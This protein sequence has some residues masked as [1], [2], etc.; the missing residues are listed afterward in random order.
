[1]TDN[2]EI[3]T[4]SD[5]SHTI[6]NRELNETYHSIHG[7]VQESMHV[8]I[9]NGL[10][11]FQ[12]RTDSG[13]ISILEVGFGTGLNALLA[14]EYAHERKVRLRYTTLEP[15]P[16]EK[17]VWSSLNY[18]VNGRQHFTSIHEVTWGCDVAVTPMFTIVKQRTSLERA[19]LRENV[20]VIFFDAFAPSVQPELWAYDSLRK[21]T[22]KLNPG[23][24]FVTYSARGQL[25]RDLKAM[26]LHIETLPGPPGKMQMVRATRN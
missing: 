18:G 7:A 4:T 19:V 26:G 24:V 6:R 13:V 9:R 11:Y 3:I 21:V 22:E 20:D 25:K 1:M 15:F 2:L 12:H 14:L 5:G 10:S 8:F 17:E 16:L 23:G